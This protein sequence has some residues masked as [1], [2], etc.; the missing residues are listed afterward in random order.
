VGGTAAVKAGARDS[1]NASV[2][3]MDVFT[4]EQTWIPLVSNIAHGRLTFL[5]E[6]LNSGEDQM[7]T[8]VIKN[9]AASDRLATRNEVFGAMPFTSNGAFEL[10]CT[11]DGYCE[12]ESDFYGWVRIR[13]EDLEYWASMG[14]ILGPDII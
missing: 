9:P 4:S 7:K 1:S 10:L 3:N 2:E 8:V 14:E 5:W 12:M 6:R 11:S 13:K